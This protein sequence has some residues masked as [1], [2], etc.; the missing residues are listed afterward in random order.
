MNFPKADVAISRKSYT[1]SS[2]EPLGLRILRAGKVSS[3][4]LC[5]QDEVRDLTGAEQG[6]E[7]N[8]V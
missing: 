7:T 8:V 4:S 1:C 3:S 5:P 6:L 2:V